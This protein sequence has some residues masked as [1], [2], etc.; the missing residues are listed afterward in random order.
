[1]PEQREKY[2]LEKLWTLGASFDD[3]LQSLMHHNDASKEI[4][5]PFKSKTLI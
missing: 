5:L 3:Q 1:M 2:E 4:P